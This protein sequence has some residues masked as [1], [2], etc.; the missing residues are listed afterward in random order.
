MAQKIMLID[1]IDGTD[2]EET[3]TYTV[4]GQDYEIDLSGANAK[5]FRDAL[6]PYLAVSR[7]VERQLVSPPTR[8]TR[9]RGGGSGRN[10]LTEVRTWAAAQGL[11]VNPRGRISKEVLD[12]Y[13]AA[14]KR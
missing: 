6:E 5:K 2:A 13:D 11:K 12:Q 10:D 1:D 9:R 8:S 14:H 7:E 3:V 4:D